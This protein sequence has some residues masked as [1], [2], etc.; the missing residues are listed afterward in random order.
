LDE[1]GV[2]RLDWVKLN[3]RQLEATMSATRRGFGLFAGISIDVIKGAAAATESAGYRSFWV[4]YAGADGL[5]VL[6]QA[7]SV[8]SRIK[9]GVGVV[10]LPTR[11][12]AS[13]AE[14]VRQNHL[15]SNRLVLGIGSPN[16]RALQTARDGIRELRSSLD[17]LIVLAA[18]GP[19][20]CRLAGE[21]ADGVL[22]NWLTPEHAKVAAAWVREGAEAAGRPMPATLAYQRV[23]L[24]KAAGERL[25][26]EGTRYATI[27]AYADHF[28]RM[29]VPP[30]D[31]C[32]AADSATAIGEGLARWNGVID[33]VVV[34][35]ITANDTLDEILAL[36]AA[37]APPH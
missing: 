37:A 35:G 10:P 14:G 21:A 4:N 1:L 29:G 25:A 3:R 12:P 8:T 22:F 27:P 11:S 18:L 13:I 26:T 6:S 28:K 24:G 19:K 2:M 31:T 16:P 17:V 32:I 36:I 34:R 5:A 15:P 9:L 7:A 33:E 20:M 23:A 30:A